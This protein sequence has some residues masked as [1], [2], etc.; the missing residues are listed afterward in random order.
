MEPY[1]FPDAIDDHK[2]NNDITLDFNA[3]QQMMHDKCMYNL[4]IVYILA[5]SP[6]YKYINSDFNVRHKL[7]WFGF[8]KK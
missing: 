7:F 6:I 3:T 8:I 2:D 4:C 5:L 1:I